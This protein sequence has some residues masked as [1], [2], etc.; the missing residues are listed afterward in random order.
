MKKTRKIFSKYLLL[1]FILTLTLSCSGTKKFMYSI[2]SDTDKL[3]GVNFNQLLDKSG[4]NK[5]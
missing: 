5:N 3:V 4:F 2:P 1:T